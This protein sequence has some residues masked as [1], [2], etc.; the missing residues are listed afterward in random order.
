M[1]RV[2]RAPDSGAPAAPVRRPPALA[3]LGRGVRAIGRAVMRGRFDARLLLGVAVVGLFAAAAALAPVVAPMNPL[4]AHYNMLLAPPKWPY[5]LGTDEFGRDIFS[6]LIWGGRVSLAVS[7][8]GVCVAAGLGVPVGLFAGYYGKLVE[9]VLMRL[10]DLV[11]V[12]PSIFL[13]L[14]LVSLIGP[15]VAS[16]VIVIG[17]TYFP[18]FARLAYVSTSATRAGLFVEASQ[19]SGASDLRIFRRHIFPNI[20]TPLLVQACLALGFGI[21]LEGSLSFLGYGVQ[22]PA[23]S[24]GGM[25]SGARAVIAQAP[26][27]L[28]WPSLT[29]TL[30]VFAIN[31]LGDGL[32]DVLDPRLRRGV[33]I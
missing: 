3:G 14:A 12:F 1:S 6:R 2:G 25:I 28:I 20:L 17:M 10:I 7:S 4:K 11:M 22:P 26:L 19:A 27:V 24:W 9:L 21:I 32:R 8:A 16:L 33:R 13:A 23:A 5:V 31:L 15:G 30:C 29:L 18:R